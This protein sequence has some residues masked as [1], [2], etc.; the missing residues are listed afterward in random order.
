MRKPMGCVLQKTGEFIQIWW[1]S[2]RRESIPTLQEQT[3]RAAHS[4]TCL[5]SSKRSVVMPRAELMSVWSLSRKIRQVVLWKSPMGE[6]SYV[7][8][9]HL[10]FLVLLATP[11][12]LWFIMILVLQ[13]QHLLANTD[14]NI[15]SHMQVT[16][17]LWN[18][19]G[20]KAWAVLSACECVCMCVRAFGKGR[21][22]KTAT[23]YSW[24]LEG[25]L[26][27]GFWK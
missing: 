8:A 1:E 11:L 20:H 24:R 17:F 23:T 10:W 21:A 6:D 5:R 2:R 19:S 7:N 15:W 14:W 27:L 9:R 3:S 22:G 12:E 4:V 26:K 25:I 18:T 13:T 16:P